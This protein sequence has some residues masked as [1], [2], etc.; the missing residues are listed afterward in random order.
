MKKRYSISSK[1]IIA[2]AF[3]IWLAIGELLGGNIIGSISFSVQVGLCFLVGYAALSLWRHEWRPLIAILAAILGIEIVTSV[4]AITRFY[5]SLNL[6]LIFISIGATFGAYRLMQVYRHTEKPRCST[7]ETML[8]NRALW[9]GIIVMATVGSAYYFSG[10]PA[11]GGLVFYGPMARDHIFHLALI[12]RLE[13]VIPPDNFV[14][15]DYPFP[16]YHF[17]NDVAQ[18]LFD[19]GFWQSGSTLDIYYRFYPGMLLFALGFLAFW[20]PAKIC[21]SRIAGAIGAAIILFGADFS[22]VLGV[23][24]MVKALP[25]LEL[26]KQKLFDPWIFWSAFSELYPLVHRPAYYHGLLIFLAGLACVAGRGGKSDISWVIAGLVWGLM[27]G[28]NYTLAAIMGTA[29]I[30][31]AGFYFFSGDRDRVRQLILCAAMLAL[32]SVPANLFIMNSAADYK[33]TFS[34][35]F[36]PGQLAKDVYGGLLGTQHSSLV[37]LFV[38][39]AAFIVVSYG[40]KLF[41][42]WSMLSGTGCR[43]HSN[44]PAMTVIF[45][46]FAISFALGFLVENEG[47][48]GTSNNII[49]FQPTGWMMGLF[50]VYPI[51]LWIKQGRTRIRSATLASLLLIGPLQALPL[52]NLGYK[53]VIGSEFLSTMSRI[54][55]EANPMDVVA[56]LPDSVQAQ[57]ILSTAPTTNNFY[58]AALTGLKAYYTTRAY[59]EN[60]SE[61]G[62]DGAE[63]YDNRTRIIRKFL[64][65]NIDDPDINFLIQ[66]GV[67]W[68]ILPVKITL[69]PLKSV[70]VWMSSTDLTVLTLGASHGSMQR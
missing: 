46:A 69:P 31:G 41:G 48:G 19:R 55:A 26:A 12:G 58:V 67:R 29:V 66:Q 43:F 32:A 37:V 61:P 35:S 10:R 59:T 50:A 63:I 56:F 24:Q 40:L 62:R 13:Y 25:N 17:F 7:A 18:T 51:F 27:A 68:V 11:D 20:V 30:C 44:K 53:V 65:G 47:Y 4:Y 52:F 16:S 1:Y 14:V 36:A 15:A 8:E 9:S 2:L 49:L 42:V 39:T 70:D 60:L 23:S 5:G 22:W 38:S 33:S 54:K 28:F 21:A 45:G 34:F 3:L 64:L 57:P 6:H